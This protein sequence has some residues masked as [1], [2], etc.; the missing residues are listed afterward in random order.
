MAGAT[1]SGMLAVDANSY[2]P[3]LDGVK[4]LV[5]KYEQRVS[6]FKGYV[7]KPGGTYWEGQTATAGQNNAA[8]GWKT[9]A[10]IQDL[11][12]RYHQSAGP[13]V[14][15]TI[16][17]ALV[18]GQ[19]MIHNAE[20]QPG[21]TVNEDLSMTYTP[22]EGMSKEQAERNAKTVADA[23]K[24][25]KAS[26]D[27]WWDGDQQVKHLTESVI[28]DVEN[29]V[30]SAAGTF[31]IGKAVKDTAPRTTDPNA[32]TVNY[33]DLYPKTA[34]PASTEAAAATATDPNAPVLGPPASGDK[35]IK[36]DPTAGAFTGSLNKMGITEPKSP[37]DKPAPPPD[38]RT[39]PAPKL[40][41]NNPADKAAIDKF[42]SIL[43]TQLPPDQVEAKVA[44]AIKGAQQD[45]PMV[46]TPEPGTPPERH[47]ESFSEA[48]HN[49]WDKGI[50]GVQDL[51]G[52]NGLE[53][54]KDAWKDMGTGIKDS[55]GELAHPTEV[56]PER[57]ENLQRM[58]DNPKAF[59]G[60]Q[61]AIAAQAAATAPLGGEAALAR[62]GLEDAAVTGVRGELTHGLPEPHTPV[63]GHAAT[64]ILSGGTHPTPVVDHPAPSAEHPSGPFPPHGEPG[65]YAYDDDGNRLRYA[66]DRPDYGPGQLEKTWDITREEQLGDIGNG[67]LNLPKPE[68]G[69]QWVQLHPNGPTKDDWVIENGHRLIDWQPGEPRRGLWDMGHVNGDEYR[70][71]EKQYLN[72]EITFE[73]YMGQYRDP[74]NYRVQDPYRNQSHID[75]GP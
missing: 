4:S 58:L 69:Q 63:A 9:I 43:S 30:N 74:Y 53:T 38:A 62:A 36:P 27:K 24:E 29:E 73:E 3:L 60:E 31:D 6:T 8:D 19:I 39:V 12:D 46:T 52:A 1:K 13:L 37:V 23:A 64:E 72:G 33:K 61:A 16:L 65:S 57:V 55:F 34:A 26:G 32:T 41:M 59:L 35:P 68:D 66:N 56:T 40:D 2:R 18:N 5:A 22:P 49:S 20:R 10:R 45:R 25:L 28:K 50:K 44:E 21:V 47:Q 67:R 15:Y 14:D 70:I 11:G 54:A 42:R 75:E 17:P 7:D 48:F 51:V 71:L